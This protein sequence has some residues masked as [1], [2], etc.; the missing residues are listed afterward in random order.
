MKPER[1]VEYERLWNTLG[2]PGP[3]PAFAAGPAWYLSLMLGTAAW[4]SGVLGMLVTGLIWNLS[5]SGAF[6]PLAVLWGVPGLLLLRVQGMG[7]FPSQLGLSLLIAGECAA[8]AAIGLAFEKPE[9]TLFGSTLLF[10]GIAAVAPRP[11]ARVLNVLAACAAWVLCLRW[12]LLGEPWQHWSQASRPPLSM[13][14]FTWL[15]CWAPLIAALLAIVRSEAHWMATRWAGLLR[16]LIVGLILA[17]AFATPLADPL[18]GFVWRDSDGSRD[19]MALWPLLSLVAG[20]VATAVAFHQRLRVLLAVC[21]FGL[22][23][24]VGHFYYA[25]GVSLLAKAVVMLL[26]GASLLGLAWALREGKV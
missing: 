2:A 16:S 17:L 7:T 22:L 10:A 26:M 19:W 25:L 9:P 14:V 4:F 23:L 15:V 3:A 21:L 12:S 6:L 1:A 20:M 5:G 24:H 18:S 11:A 8:V 13:A